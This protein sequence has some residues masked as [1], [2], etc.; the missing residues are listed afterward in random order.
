MATLTAVPGRVYMEMGPGRAL[1]SLAQANGVPAGQVI[2]ALRHPEQKMADDAWHVASIARLWACGVAVD[3]APIWGGRAGT[4]CRCRPMP[5][6]RSPISSNPA[7]PPRRPRRRLPERI[8]DLAHWGWRR[9]GAG[10]RGFDLDDLAETAPETWLVFADAEAEG[11][12]RRNPAAARRRAPGRHRPGGRCLCPRWRGRLSPAPERG[13]DGYDLLLRD[14][15]ARRHGA[16]RIAHFWLVT[17]AR[18][19]APAPASCTATSNRASF[20]A[21]PGAGD[22]RGKPARPDQLT[23]LTTGAAQVKGGKLAYP[24]KAMVLG[25]VRVIPRED[26]RGSPLRCWIDLG[27]PATPVQPRWST[28]WSKRTCCRPARCRP[29]RR[30]AL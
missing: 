12:R 17:R 1:S 18:P 8:A 7:L 22:G 2:P 26:C 4:A 20:A 27:R 9:I 24:E 5:S 28:A 23:P 19:S 29:A 25:P 13:R 15:V 16:A 10:D 6:R 14:L 3:W 21:V 30:A 11:L